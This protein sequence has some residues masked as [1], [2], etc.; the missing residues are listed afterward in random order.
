MRGQAAH[1][2]GL[3]RCK[4]AGAG[5]LGPQARA[6]PGCRPTTP[7]ARRSGGA[8]ATWCCTRGPWP[9]PSTCA[10]CR[11]TGRRSPRRRPSCRWA[12][13]PCAAPGVWGW[14]LEWWCRGSCSQRLRAAPPAGAGTRQHS[15]PRRHSP[16][17]AAPG[18]ASFHAA[19]LRAARPRR[20]A[21]G[22]PA[23]PPLLALT[24]RP[25]RGADHPVC[26]QPDARQRGRAAQR[27]AGVWRP[28]ALLHRD[29]RGGA[30]QG[31]R[32]CGVHAP[33]VGAAA[34]AVAAAAAAAAAAGLGVRPP[35]LRVCA[36]QAHPCRP[37]AL[38]RT[39]CLQHPAADTPPPPAAPRSRARHAA[40]AKDAI[41]KKFKAT[42]TAIY[43]KNRG[44]AAAA[45]AAMQEQGGW[46]MRPGVCT[47]LGGGAG[48]AARAGGGC[49]GCRQSSGAARWPAAAAAAAPHLAGACPAPAGAPDQAA[50]DEHFKQVKI[51]RAEFATTRTVASL[52]SRCALRAA[53]CGLPAAGR[54]CAWAHTWPLPACRDRISAIPHARHAHPPPLPHA[55]TPSLPHSLTPPLQGTC[56]WPTCASR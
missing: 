15:P 20:V 49:S 33:Q 25:P 19:S 3:R 17:P 16:L 53:R 8:R 42:Q 48:R 37:L 32:V 14:G 2:R 30:A 44:A 46:R 24:P 45:R 54:G 29:Q 28:G 41:E 56:T 34:A 9:P 6:C 18:L 10:S 39:A 26:G 47:R 11:W 52:F 12:G 55:P 43:A 38:Q 4:L 5:P 23:R 31:L 1:L 50:L 7:P 21:G 36:G 13:G 40:A 27:D 51:V 22:A 35:C